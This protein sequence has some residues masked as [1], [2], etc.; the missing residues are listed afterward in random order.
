[1]RSLV[2]AVVAF[3]SATA[4]AT[5]IDFSL[6]SI[7][8]ITTFEVG[9]AEYN[10]LV[11]TKGYDFSGTLDYQVSTE[12]LA[13]CPPCDDKLTIERTDGHVFSLDSFDFSDGGANQPLMMTGYT[14]GGGSMQMELPL[15]S[16]SLT[17]LNV[18]WSG[19]TSVVID[20]PTGGYVGVIDNIVV[21]SAVPIPATVWLFG[22][23]LAG[24]GWLRRKQ[25]V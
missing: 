15:V 6:G 14:L 24:L 25:T 1:M 17:T 4:S 12:V 23:A 3:F 2:L 19:L 8:N 9:G 7:T 13:W 21:T 5:T 20:N 22:S 16:G 18:G 10:G 11:S